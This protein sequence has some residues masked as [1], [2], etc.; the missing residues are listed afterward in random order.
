MN[1]MSS[2]GQSS[3]VISE[4]PSRPTRPYF[5]SFTLRGSLSMSLPK[6]YMFIDTFSASLDVVSLIY[7]SRIVRA[8]TEDDAQPQARLDLSQPRG[9]CPGNDVGE[10]W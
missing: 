9:G 5:L 8:V 7:V 1:L 10:R 4:G 6:S 3:L 2:A